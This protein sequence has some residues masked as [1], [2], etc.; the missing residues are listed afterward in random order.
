MAK[1]TDPSLSPSDSLTP[2]I[3]GATAVCIV[4][5]AGSETQANFAISGFHKGCTLGTLLTTPP[6]VGVP[7]RHAQSY[8]H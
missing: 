6:K 2:A 3:H 1:K 7:V 4:L 8:S 5:A